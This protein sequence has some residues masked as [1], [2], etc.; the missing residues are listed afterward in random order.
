TLLIALTAAVAAAAIAAGVMVSAKFAPPNAQAEEPDSEE[1]E[2]E[3]PEGAPSAGGDRRAVKP[4]PIGLPELLVSLLG[5][6]IWFAGSAGGYIAT[7]SSEGAVAYTELAFFIL[8]AI[9]A[10]SAAVVAHGAYIGHTGGFCRFLSIVPPIF[11]SYWMI[12]L[13]RIHASDPVIV[14]YGYECL[15]IAASAM[16]FYFLAGY[17]YGKP[18]PGKTLFCIVMTVFL[19][20]AVSADGAFALYEKMIILSAPLISLANILPLSRWLVRREK[21]PEQA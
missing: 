17:Q 4:V 7:R 20:G 2:G 11:F 14:N 3:G 6:V 5:C 9:S 21:Q 8:S 19:C 1:P 10:V 13:Y 15:A 16:S 12:L 18:E